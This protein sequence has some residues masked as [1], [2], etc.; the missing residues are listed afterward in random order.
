MRQACNAD[1][2]KLTCIKMFSL[3][4]WDQ[5]ASWEPNLYNEFPFI[6]QKSFKAQTIYNPTG[7]FSLKLPV[8]V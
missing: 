3:G 5:V 1:N 2:E 6:G 4:T 7:Q 8:T